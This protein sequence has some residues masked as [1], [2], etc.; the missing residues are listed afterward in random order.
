MPTN[1]KTP[2]LGLNNWLETDKPMRTDF[3]S[4]N[5][6]IDEALGGHMKDT[7][8]HLTEEDRTVLSAPAH[9]MQYFGDGSASTQKTLPFAAGAVLVF[10]TGKPPVEWDAQGEKLIY[11]AALATKEN[12]GGGISLN[13][14]TLTVQQTQ[15]GEKET[16]FYNLNASNTVY[17]CIA[18]H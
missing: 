13:G 6:L 10:A 8:L 2:H 9:I 17:G 12:S 18:F 1:Q 16:A 15:E 7:T 4:D 14:Q 11:H 5:L 3:T